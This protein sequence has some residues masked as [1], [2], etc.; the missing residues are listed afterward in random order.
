MSEPAKKML[1][2]ETDAAAIDAAALD[3]LRLLDPSGAAGI[4]TRV[5]RAYVGSMERLMSQFDA[6]LA[7]HDL[8]TLRHVAHTLRSSSASVGAQSMA[9]ACSVVEALTR[10]GDARAVGAP[11][12]DMLHE[13][14]RA[15]AAVRDILDTQG[16][17]A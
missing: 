6:A 3:K 12:Q 10:D 9:R 8:T 11:A 14:R 15:L 16:P 5:L 7:A 17:A 4:V 1:E 13:S 2:A